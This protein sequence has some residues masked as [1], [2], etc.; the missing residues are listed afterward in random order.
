MRPSVAA[1]FMLLLGACQSIPERDPAISL[2]KPDASSYSQAQSAAWSARRAIRPS[3]RW[4]PD[5][6]AC[7][8]GGAV[9]KSFGLDG[10]V[11]ELEPPDTPPST[12][13]QAP[14]RGRQLDTS[15][16][17]DKVWKAVS[18]NGNILLEGVDTERW[19]VVTA[20]G[21]GVLKYGTA[22]WVYGEELDVQ[23][24][25]W[26]RGDSQ[27]LVYYRFDES[28]VPTYPLTL[29]MT[30][31]RPTLSTKPIQSPV[32]PIPSPTL[33]ILISRPVSVGC[34]PPSRPKLTVIRGI[35][36]VSP[37]IASTRSCFTAPTG[38][39]KLGNLFGWTCLR[40]IRGWFCPRPSRVGMRT[41]PNAASCQTVRG[42]FTKPSN[43]DGWAG[44][45]VP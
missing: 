4:H 37:L 5:G 29:D 36:S 18:R 11:L 20:E 38:G 7:W 25:M 45:C 2:E 33:S 21:E 32:I 27:G 26:W 30:S 39:N 24:A 8:I 44:S 19:Q 23:E 31:T 6:S 34:S 17:P 42:S 35:S 22:S 16:S 15:I 9:D 41:I 28:G 3:V 10:A 40:V 14:K 12:S 1:S 43:L 13:R